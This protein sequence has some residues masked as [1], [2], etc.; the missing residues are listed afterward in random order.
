MAHKSKTRQYEGNLNYGAS[1]DIIEKAKSLRQRMTETEK[2]LWSQLRAKQLDG[3]KFRRQHP[4]WI[5]IADFYCHEAKLVVELDG[6]I[7]FQ[8]GVKEYDFN[9]TAEIER[10]EIKVVRFK[11]EEVL[12]NLNEVLKKISDECK[13]RSP[14]PALPLQGKGGPTHKP[15]L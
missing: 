4:I 7:H 14:S 8:S 15:L 5:F 6:G 12:Q 11:N 9:R 2:L 1:P 13:A 10:F 3:F